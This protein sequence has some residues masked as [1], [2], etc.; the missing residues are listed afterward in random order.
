MTSTFRPRASHLLRTLTI[1]W[2]VAAG[3]SNRPRAQADDA[4]ISP[5][6]AAEI[7][8]GVPDA[9]PDVPPD[10]APD[11]AVDAPP[12]PGIVTVHV[13]DPF[14]GTPSSGIRVL[15]AGPNDEPIRRRRIRRSWWS[16]RRAT[17][18]GWRP[19]MALWST[20]SPR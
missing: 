12:P 3:C 2:L 18:S 7:D 14:D 9:S 10:A 20:S 4:G 11:A 19:R 1:A 17:G 6:D 8:G 16:R 13:F 5:G 15:F